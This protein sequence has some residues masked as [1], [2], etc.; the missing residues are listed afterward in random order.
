MYINIHGSSCKECCGK[1]IDPISKV[2]D[3]ETEFQ[4]WFA[5]LQPYALAACSLHQQQEWVH[6]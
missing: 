5:S 4:G 6:L 1:K 3:Q 2:A